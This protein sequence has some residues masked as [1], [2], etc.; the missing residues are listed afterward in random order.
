MSL[1][2]SL[3]DWKERAKAVHTLY[4]SSTRQVEIGPCLLLSITMSRSAAAAGDWLT[5][6]EGIGVQAVTRFVLYSAQGSHFEE[7]HPPISLPKGLYV[8]LGN[9]SFVVTIRYVALKD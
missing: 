9:G 1:K 6:A 5:I 8:N 4:L 3:L 2:S 7:F